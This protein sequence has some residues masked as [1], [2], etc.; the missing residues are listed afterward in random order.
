M[1]LKLIELMYKTENKLTLYLKIKNRKFQ[2]VYLLGEIDQINNKFDNMS[3]ENIFT[4][5]EVQ[6]VAEPNMNLTARS[7][8]SSAD[9]AI[10]NCALQ[11]VT[12]LIELVQN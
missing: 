3:A 12:S 6:S 8:N 5:S 4:N 7:N 10:H 2:N 1:N 11:Y 9:T